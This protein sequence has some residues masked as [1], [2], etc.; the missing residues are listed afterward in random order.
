MIIIKLVSTNFHTVLRMTVEMT[1]IALKFIAFKIIESTSMMLYQNKLFFVILTYSN[2]NNTMCSFM[3]LRRFEKC[4]CRL[5]MN[6][7]PICKVPSRIL[8]NY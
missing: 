5:H 3:Y 6:D 2:V 1:Q 8:E 7:G 4:C